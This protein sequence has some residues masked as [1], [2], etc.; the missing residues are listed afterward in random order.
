MWILNFLNSFQN[1]HFESNKREFKEEKWIKRNELRERNK[2]QKQINIELVKVKSN[3][4]LNW[5]TFTLAFGSDKIFN[6]A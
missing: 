5:I 3:C 2:Q 1:V 4:Q 6:L